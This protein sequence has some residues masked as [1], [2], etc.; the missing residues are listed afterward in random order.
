MTI[1]RGTLSEVSAL[2]DD[3]GVLSLYVDADP[4]KQAH[5][6]TAWEV[7]VKNELAGLRSSVRENET[8][9]RAKAIHAAL[10]D[11]EPEIERTAHPSTRGRGRA[12]FAALGASTRLSLEFQLPT[13]TRAV[14]SATTFIRPLLAAYAQGRPAGLVTLSRSGVVVYGWDFGAVEEVER[15]SIHA[16]TS[17]WRRMKGPAGSNPALSQ[18]T[19]PQHD[20]FERRL[21]EH[22]AGLVADVG[23]ELAGL[24]DARGWGRLVLAGDGK[25]RTALKRELG[26][27]PGGEL[28]ETDRKLE[29]L[30]PTELGAALLP[31]L[32]K[33]RVRQ[34]AELA[35]RVDDIARAGGGA[36]TGVRATVAALAEGRVS[37]LLIEHGRDFAGVRAPD[38]TLFAELGSAVGADASQLVDEPRL[39]ERMI[40]RALATGADVITLEASEAAPLDDAGG[41][42]A[43]LRW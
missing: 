23:A 27:T 5:R 39:G 35:L 18:Q 31:E 3:L 38:G 10:D 8:R 42:G 13:E 36:T 33:A 15:W 9:E 6:P 29:S 2:R 19:A 11:L 43:L 34:R 21:E 37:E 7:Q 20:R 4:S 1:D 12:L 24:R 14:L 25:L 28:V 17:E 32:E 41:V 30:G 26:Q 40:E 22:Q 16:E